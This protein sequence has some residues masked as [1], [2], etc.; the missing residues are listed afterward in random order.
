MSLSVIVITRDEERHIRDCLASVRDLADELL[1][2][3][4]GSL[5]G[6][7]EIAR[8]MGARIE[9]RPFDNFAKQR[10]A[11]IEMAKGD[12]IFFID[13][14][15][16]C[17]RYLGAEIEF[18]VLMAEPEIAGFWVPRRNI[19]FGKEIKH[20]GWSPDYQPRILRKGRG[21]FD[22]TREVHELLVWDGPARNLTQA[23]THFNYESFSQFRKRNYKYT[24][25]EARICSKKA[26]ARESGVL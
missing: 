5:D 21:H 6:T 14:D 9:I 20:T 23:L 12:W 10:N 17:T 24:E 2:V 1:V 13:A 16:R 26:S 18:R 19:I 22:P 11:A 15:E 25:Y 8:E 3:D 7:V 4:S